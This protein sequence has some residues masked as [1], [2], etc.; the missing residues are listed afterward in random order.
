MRSYS[1]AFIESFYS[2]E[3]RSRGLRRSPGQRRSGC[4]PVVRESD[5][6]QSRHHSQSISN[7]PDF[8]AFL[9][10]PSHGNLGNSTCEAA[11]QEKDLDIETEVIDPRAPE[12]ILRRRTGEQL[13]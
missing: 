11:R 10:R 5:S 6:E 4:K 12:D 7:E 1:S 9:V 3:L 2:G 13:E 8:A